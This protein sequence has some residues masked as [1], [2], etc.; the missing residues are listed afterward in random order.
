M[1]SQNMNSLVIPVDPFTNP[2]DVLIF[3]NSIILAPMHRHNLGANYLQKSVDFP[4]LPGA[5]W[6]AVII[7]I[8]F[9]IFLS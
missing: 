1:F 9:C 2:N 8:G 5:S 3:H 6:I 7:I 4:I